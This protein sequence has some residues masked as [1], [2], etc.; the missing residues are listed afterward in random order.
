MPAVSDVKTG[1]AD[2]GGRG[3]LSQVSHCQGDV[4]REYEGNGRSVVGILR[5][6]TRTCGTYLSLFGNSPMLLLLPWVRRERSLQDQEKK[7]KPSPPWDNWVA[8]TLACH[9]ECAV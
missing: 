9:G 7:K 4:C 3:V 6:D 1:H 5:S 8:K 2:V